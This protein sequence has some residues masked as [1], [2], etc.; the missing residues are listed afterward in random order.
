VVPLAA[1][2]GTDGSKHVLTAI[3]PPTWDDVD[4]EMVSAAV[5]EVS[6]AVTEVSAAVAEVSAAVDAV[7]AA[8]T[9]DGA[10]VVAPKRKRAAA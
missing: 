10:P 8:D 9:A 5:T 7:D 6:A 3:A 1:D 4:I 2:G